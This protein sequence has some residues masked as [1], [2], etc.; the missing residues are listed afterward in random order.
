MRKTDYSVLAERYAAHRRV[1]PRVAE[2]LANTVHHG[3]RVMEVGCGT[4]NY[5]AAVCALSAAAGIGVDPSPEMLNATAGTAARQRR[6]VGR[7]EQLGVAAGQ[8]DLIFSVDVIHHVVDRDAGYREAFRVLRK[9]GR[10][11]TVTESDMMLRTRDPQSRYFP[12]TIDVELARYP[13]IET[14]R[15]EM[16]RA[17]FENLSEDVAEWTSEVIDTAPFREKVFSS[18]L[19]ISESAFDS[20]LARLEAAVQAG[21]VRYVSRYVLLWGTKVPSVPSA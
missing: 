5:L 7:A 20:G 11:C 18:L 10:V 3:A 1:N 13:S 2:L 19:Y 9:G 6:L 17:G 4:G 14:L 16:Q 15:R 12:E 21:A 8:F